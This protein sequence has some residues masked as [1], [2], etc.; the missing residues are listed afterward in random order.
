MTVT[1][2]PGWPGA[3][4]ARGASA[5]GW[6][7]AAA[8]PVIGL[9]SLVEHERIDP[10]WTNP[11]L[12]FVL[13]LTVGVLATVLASAAG[14]SARLRGAPGALPLSRQFPEHPR[15]RRHAGAC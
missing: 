7:L 5:L 3:S 14:E 6:A 9:L 1:G 8:L 15:G 2:A 10:N 12:H 13:F 11:R 4:A